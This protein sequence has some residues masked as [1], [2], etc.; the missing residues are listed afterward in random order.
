MSFTV[1]QRRREIG[2]RAA[3]GADARH[4]LTGIL[5]RATLQLVVGVVIGHGLSIVVDRVTGGEILNGKGL[6]V[7]PVIAMV[8]LVVGFLAAAGPARRGLR[9]DPTEALRAG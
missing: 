5:A 7:V 8:M 9:V 3:L 4:I 2:L 1:N 6:V